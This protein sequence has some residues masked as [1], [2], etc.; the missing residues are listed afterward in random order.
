MIQFTK[1]YEFLG[2][3]WF[4]AQI[5]FQKTFYFKKFSFG[6][7]QIFS[8]IDLIS[9][10]SVLGNAVTCSN[11]LIMLWLLTFSK[12]TLKF[13]PIQKPRTTNQ[14]AAMLVFWNDWL[15]SN[16]SI[17]AKQVLEGMVTRG[18]TYTKKI[19]S[20]RI[21]NVWLERTYFRTIKRVINLSIRPDIQL[22]LIFIQ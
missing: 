10:I 5:D 14:I 16:A 1:I 3:N 18:L 20:V 4:L 21:L 2:E 22:N 8:R 7:F 17:I 15:L 13:H 19:D 6:L 12:Q 11:N 9:E